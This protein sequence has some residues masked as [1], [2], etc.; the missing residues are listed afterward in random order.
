M[1]K[2]SRPVNRDDSKNKSSGSAVY[3]SDVIKPGMLAMAVKSADFQHGKINTIK[4]PEL[5]EGYF[6]VDGKSFTGMNRASIV[7]Q[8]WPFFAESEVLY[9]GQ[10]VCAY[11]GPRIEVCEK[12]CIQTKI[13]YTPLPAVSVIEDAADFFNDY[14]IIK[15]NPDKSF[16][17]AAQIFENQYRTGMQEQAYMEPQGM[18]AEFNEGKLTVYGSMQCPYYIKNSL[19][20]AFNLD[21]DNVRVIQ[22]ITGG[23][24]GGKE[25]YPSILAGQAAAAAIVSGKPVKI[26]LDRRND[27]SV[28]PKRHP[29]LI[30]IRTAVDSEGNITAMDID[31]RIDAG[32]YESLSGVVLERAIFIST[33][34]YNIAD[35]K[36]RGRTMKTNHIPSGAFRGFGGPQALFAAD[37]N[38]YYLARKLN[39]APLELKR[40]YLFQRGDI[41]VTSG[42]F[43]DDIKLEE[44]I[45]RVEEISDYSS[46]WAEYEKTSQA[47][48]K[49]KGIGI[50]FAAHGGAFT[51]NGEQEIIK[52]LVRLE[53]EPDKQTSAGGRLRILVSNVEMGQG[54][55]ITLRKIV[56]EESGLPLEAIIFTN[57]DTDIVPD[58][59]PTVASRTIMIVGKL[60][61]DAAA[62]LKQKIED[63]INS[64]SSVEKSYVHPPEFD[65]DEETF[66]GDAYPAYSWAVNVIEVEIDPITFE[67]K[68]TGSWAVYDV[69]TPIDIKILE[70]QMQG[71]TAQSLGYSS[72]EKMQMINGKPA[73]VSFTDYTIPTTLDF[74]DT[75]CVFI[76]NPYRYG[77]FGAKAA[78]E[79]PNEGPAAAFTAAISQ[80]SGRMITEIPVTP[81]MLEE[82][83]R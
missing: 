11:T 20:N 42:I 63:D 64:P 26:V 73:Q 25:D 47:G 59:G 13:E 51:G 66:T 31:C 36:V 46:K 16:K 17:E 55:S 53:W 9:F 24:F 23:A 70:G 69:G 30:K 7:A 14:T 10:P 81:E 50:S 56:A 74:P 1:H 15:G 5:P 19:K 27:M 52:S 72:I 82:Q 45:S 57:P 62:M 29:S 3:I 2:I 58:S 8:D 77:P 37:M 67:I 65:W 60:I 12:L 61:Q 49:M 76:D 33:G 83:L 34:A 18:I 75:E 35:V 38:M 44:M 71:G 28:T 22:S 39:A 54:A 78:G 41:S 79:L 40:R 68:I 21:D 43:R 4:K 6:Y 48:D 80:A 32:A